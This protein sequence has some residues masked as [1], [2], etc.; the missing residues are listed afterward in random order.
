MTELSPVGT[1]AV[2][3][4]SV[5][6]AALSGRPALG[7]D[8]M[9]ADE[10][11]DPL[12]EQRGPG[13]PPARSRRSVIERYFGQEHPATTR[14]GWFDTGDLA[15]IDG[16]GNLMITG[17][18][19]DLI[20]SGGE[21]INPAEIEAV[22]CTLPQV[23]LAAV[24]GRNDHEMGRA[25]DPAGRDARGPGHFRSRPARVAARPRR[26]LVDPRRRGARAEHAAGGHGQDRQD[27]PESRVWRWLRRG[28]EPGFPDRLRPCRRRWS[29]GTGAVDRPPSQVEAGAPASKAKPSSA[30]SAGRGKRPTKA[31]QRA[32]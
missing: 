14:D 18:A 27:P 8:L 20:K 22:V 5:R 29:R 25:P 16:R 19:K 24:I 26:L 17:R 21:W 31:E 11:G 3:S 4:D 28:V 9:L 13:G 15:R 1:L 7:V 10:N 32:G 2:L 12:Q 6:N 30:K 23:S